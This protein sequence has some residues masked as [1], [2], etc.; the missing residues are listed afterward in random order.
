MGRLRG[1]FRLR[2]A[3]GGQDGVIFA[4][5]R[6]GDDQVATDQFGGLL[7]LRLHDDDAGDRGGGED[8]VGAGGER[9]FNHQTPVQHDGCA[10]GD[11]GAL[12][13]QVPGGDDDG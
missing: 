8:A 9:S 3:Y 5:L 10:A 13:V 7:V 12:L 1:A 4:S 2:G 11:K 6:G